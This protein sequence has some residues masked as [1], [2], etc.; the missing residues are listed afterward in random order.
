MAAHPQ[1]AGP[2]LGCPFCGHRR[3][4]LLSVVSG[5][6]LGVLRVR[7]YACRG[8]DC[9]ARLYTHELMDGFASQETLLV[10]GNRYK[11]KR[12]RFD[13]AQCL[14]GA[15]KWIV[16]AAY[17]HDDPERLKTYA[18]RCARCLRVMHTRERLKGISASPTPREERSHRP[19]PHL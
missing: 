19:H 16:C 15:R 8:H 6:E 13:E 11:G 7:I 9:T 5:R 14:C 3:W 10:Q 17:R 2:D 4:R 1:G 12:A 18:Y